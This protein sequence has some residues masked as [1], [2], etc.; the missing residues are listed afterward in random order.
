MNTILIIVG[1]VIT[2]LVINFLRNTV[3][4]SVM[5]PSETKEKIKN[6]PGVIIDVRTPSEYKKGHLKE[7]DYNLDIMSGTFKQKWKSS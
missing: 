5:N 1:V 6:D 3:F 7:A 4:N 2:F